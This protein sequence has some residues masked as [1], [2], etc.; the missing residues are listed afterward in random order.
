ME[1]VSLNEEKEILHAVYIL[2]FQNKQI[3]ATII[4]K[5][6][7]FQEIC[8]DIKSSIFL[9]LFPF[10]IIF[11][12]QLTLVSLG[13]SLKPSLGEVNGERLQDFFRFAFPLI[14]CTWNN[15]F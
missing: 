2:K 1:V 15:V 10:H 8:K 12:Y 4:E 9:K 13:Q 7:K 6:I 11:N 14:P 5:P 3:K